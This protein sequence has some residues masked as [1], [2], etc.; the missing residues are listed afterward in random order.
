MARTRTYG[1]LAKYLNTPE[2]MA[3]FCRHYGVPDDVHLEYRYWEDTLP[4]VP[5][6]LIPSVVAII[7]GGVRFP[8]DPLLAN[9]LEFFNLSPT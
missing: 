1:K 3:Q 7:E 6:D 5:G 4:A 9:F 8:L 2:A